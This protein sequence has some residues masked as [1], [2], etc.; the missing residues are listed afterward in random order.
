MQV[1]YDRDADL[2][3]LKGLERLWNRSG[4]RIERRE[5]IV[6]QGQERRVPGDGNGGGSQ[7]RGCRHGPLT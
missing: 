5:W 2:K 3:Y 7:G 6:V 4:G 1:F